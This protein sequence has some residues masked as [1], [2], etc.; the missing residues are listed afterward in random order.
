MCLIDL[1]QSYSQDFVKSD[2][3]HVMQ[4][5]DGLIEHDDQHHMVGTVRSNLGAESSKTSKHRIFHK[6]C[7]NVAQNEFKQVL[8][9]VDSQSEASGR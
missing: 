6:E 4:V 2:I 7:F 8:I 3:L 1:E 9:K 5:M